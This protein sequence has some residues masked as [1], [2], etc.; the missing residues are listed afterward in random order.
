MSKSMIKM[1]MEFLFLLVTLIGLY[2]A[3]GALLIICFFIATV[4][5]S[6]NINGKETKFELIKNKTVSSAVNLLFELISIYGIL[7]LFYGEKVHDTAM[8]INNL[9]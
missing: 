9:I 1:F 4:S 8:N 7:L 5:L 3:G 2:S 6:I